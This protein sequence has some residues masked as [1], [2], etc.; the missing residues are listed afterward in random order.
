MKY[1]NPIRRALEAAAV[2]GLLFIATAASAQTLFDDFIGS[3]VD[4]ATWYPR[5][6]SGTIVQNDDSLIR[7]TTGTLTTSQR[8]FLVTNSI[9]NNPFAGALTITFDNLTLA[10]TATENEPTWGNAFY[11]AV[12]RASTDDGAA[13]NDTVAGKYTAV[14]GD[15]ITALGLNVRKSDTAT[16][17]QIID[18]GAANHTTASFN[19]SGTPTDIVWIIDGTGGIGSWSVALTGATFTDTGLSSASGSFIKFNEAELDAAGTSVSRL[20][21]GA[22]NVGPV[23][24]F[25]AVTLDSVTLSTVPE[26]SAYALILSGLV[27]GLILV[28][29][30]PGTA[31]RR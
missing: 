2:A 6:T 28:R 20:A 11:A 17:L 15:Y 22:I 16:I 12:G 1:H 3:S 18:R 21:F 27:G 5:K 24:D 25:T 26:P 4:T 30:R 13:L 8:A 23:V 9:N 31:R 19:L 14:G 10:G 7:F 29:R